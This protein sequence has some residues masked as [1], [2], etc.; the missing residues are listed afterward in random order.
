MNTDQLTASVTLKPFIRS[1]LIALGLLFP[2]PAHAVPVETGIRLAPLPLPKI[3]PDQVKGMTKCMAEKDRIVPHKEGYRRG[4]FLAT[5][6][7]AVE[8]APLDLKPDGTK[9]ITGTQM[10]KVFKTRKGF[11]SVGVLALTRQGHYEVAGCYQVYFS[12]LDERPWSSLHSGLTDHLSPALKTLFF[13]YPE[14]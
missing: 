13:S 5:V 12:P 11:G 7:N 8:N 9:K 14:Q 2:A 6:L 4:K 3:H 1:G 10:L